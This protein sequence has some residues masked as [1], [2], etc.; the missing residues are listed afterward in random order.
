MVECCEVSYFVVRL[1]VKE[2][3][4]R[5]NGEMSTAA[6]VGGVDVREGGSKFGSVGGRSWTAR[7]D[8]GMNGTVRREAGR[9]GG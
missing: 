8:G 7:G 4:R 3:G 2:S 9:G 6:T 1:N 5:L